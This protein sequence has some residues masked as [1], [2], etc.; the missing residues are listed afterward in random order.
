VVAHANSSWVSPRHL[1]KKIRT[2]GSTHRY[3]FS[4]SANI[5]ERFELF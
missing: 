4:V 3:L 5:E 2:C 1:S